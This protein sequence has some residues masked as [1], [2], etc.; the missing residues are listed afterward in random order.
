[1]RFMPRPTLPCLFLTA[2]LLVTGCAAPTSEDPASRTAALDDTPTPAPVLEWPTPEGWSA[3]RFPFPLFFAPDLAHR[4]IEE[5]R[6]MPGYGDVAA[7]DYFSYSFVWWLDDA[8]PMG[9][10]AMEGEL[11]EYFAGLA[12]TFD[13]AHFDASAHSATVMEWPPGHY[14]GEVNT[15]DPF[16]AS[17]PLVLRLAV[18]VER[19]GGRPLVGF[20]LSPASASE[21]VWQELARQR[22]TLR[23]R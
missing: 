10:E 18:D 1:M 8:P 2:G 3:E 7:P 12:R 20:R 21:A 13:A 19:C 15:V 14:Q 5:L 22:R 4:G 11:T 16:H 17:A 9:P 23:C 6:F